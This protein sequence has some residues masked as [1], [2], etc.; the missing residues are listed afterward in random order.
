MRYAIGVGSNR[1]DR[2]AR[3]ARAESLLPAS[4]AIRERA[5]LWENRAVGGPPGQ[6]AFLNGAWIVDTAL[7]P[8][9]LL[10]HLRGVEDA[11]GRVRG[12]GD[13]PRTLDLD[14]LLAED[15][16]VVD[17][18]FLALPHPR[19]HRRDFVMVPLLAIA[20]DWPHPGFGCRLDAI[21]RGWWS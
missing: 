6:P 20:A 3:I 2:A 10:W 11:C 4:V 7:G 14:C 15:G 18:P 12:I 1:G 8:H 19:L 13:G 5:P 16:R 9:Q 21:P 17:D